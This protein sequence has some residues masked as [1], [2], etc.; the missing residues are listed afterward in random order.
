V[1]TVFIGVSGPGFSQ[2]RRFH[3]PGER[4]SIRDRAARGA[5]ALVRL[6]IRSP[7]DFAVPFI[8]EWKPRA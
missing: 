1:G 7:M 5:L 4:A 8:W 6:A 3:F 2:A